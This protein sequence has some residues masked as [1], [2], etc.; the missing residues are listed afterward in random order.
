MNAA[1]VNIAEHSCIMCSGVSLVESVET[2]NFPFG[3]DEFLI[4]VDVPVVSCSDCGFSFTDSRAE[5]IRHDAACRHQGLLTP[6]RMREIRAVYDMDRRQFAT[7]FKIG[8]ASLERWENRK[9]FISG[10]SSY[11]LTAL[12]DKEVGLKLIASA[13]TI[14]VFPVQSNVIHIDFSALRSS[15]ERFAK[16]LERR[17]LFS[18]KRNNG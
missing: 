10:Q 7:A 8:H 13:E 2:E 9:L 3:D 18:L 17:E 15:S 1:Q 11:Y 12:A 4:S 16:A 14:N 5:A 6:D